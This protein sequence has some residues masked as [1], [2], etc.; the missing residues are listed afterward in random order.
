MRFA[1]P[2]SQSIGT[3]TIPTT[4]SSKR[5]SKA[6]VHAFTAHMQIPVPLPGLPDQRVL[7]Y[8]TATK[9][10]AVPE[11]ISKTHQVHRRI[12][13]ICVKI[14]CVKAHGVWGSYGKATS[15]TRT[16]IEAKCKKRR[17]YDEG[18]A[19]RYAKDAQMEA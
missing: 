14:R 1:S 4:S 8:G 10:T 6:D 19:A 2:S 3:V 5:S 16:R 12:H 17:E 18:Y 13:D 7:Q 9:S 11:S 15:I